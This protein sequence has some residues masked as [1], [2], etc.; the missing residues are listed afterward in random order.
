VKYL[1]I[2]LEGFLS[3]KHLEMDLSSVSHA[4]V[5]G[6]NGS[7]KS[8]IPL[9]IAWVLFG[10]ARFGNDTD[11]I[12][13]DESDAAV[14][15]LTVEDDEG[16]QW[17]FVRGREYGSGGFLR[18]YLLTDGEW[19][20]HSDHTQATAQRD[21]YNVVNISE[22]AFYSLVL[23]DQSSHAGGT[24]FT[25]SDS[26][27]RRSIL[28]G[29]IP[30]LDQW[31]MFKNRASERLSEA[32]KDSERITNQIDSV[33]GQI[34]ST[35]ERRDGLQEQI[36]EDT[37]AAIEAR[38]V[39]LD[40]RITKL[41]KQIAGSG[42]SEVERIQTEIES[43]RTAH[44]LKVSKQQSAIRDLDDELD[45]IEDKEERVEQAEADLT[46]LE[47][48]DEALRSER[49]ALKSEIDDLEP[50]IDE[51]REGVT[52]LEDRMGESTS[53]VE[54][55]RSRL[56]DVR[57]RIDGLELAS[58][59]DNGVCPTCD[60]P[61]SQDKCE[62]LL[63][64]N[65]REKRELGDQ[66]DEAEEAL[67]KLKRRLTDTR[68]LLGTTENRL[69]KAES[70]RDDIKARLKRSAPDI[71]AAQDRVDRLRS[72]LKDLRDPDEVNSALKK[73]KRKLS[74]LNEEFEQDTLKVLEQELS[75]A[76]EDD[77]DD[78]L[79]RELDDL[80]SEREDL[81]T[82]RTRYDRLSGALQESVATLERLEGEVDQL[83]RDAVDK[84][85]L[86]DDLTWA[87]KAAGPK[88]IPSMLLDG[89][90]GAIEDE[91]NRILEQLAG[92]AQMRVEFRQSRENKSGNGSKDVLDIVVHTAGDRERLI[93]S[94]SFGE[95]IRL[96]ISNL[97][98]MIK[99]FNERSG[100]RLISTV[101]LDEPL[102]PLDQRSVPAFIEVLR[103]AMNTG[104]VDSMWVITHDQT[105]IDALPQEVKVSRGP[106]GDSQVV[107]A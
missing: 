9:G 11:S 69:A 33:R 104:I 62:S 103:V 101:F 92:P 53:T 105:V 84:R 74:E 61:L 85:R 40:K 93:E 98:A 71:E 60:S 72:E 2:E 81:A 29:L 6:A 39:K 5:T 59:K 51:H 13:N 73:A 67:G 30:E 25:A 23:M 17:R 76:R 79:R 66:L 97:F 16:N 3:Y 44:D 56:A 87:E 36:G 26:N 34:E 41:T 106:N 20:Q 80:K 42:D 88:G 83:G 15:T 18:S 27:T 21:I 47:N 37:A 100:R 96:S 48:Q 75:R 91:Q 89:I 35:E 46:R 68:T 90:L 19:E 78:Q 107:V 38:G 14:G 45:K 49:K 4:A 63:E 94:F 86:I 55:L 32:K 77:R 7:G 54:R 52:R 102:G 12:V 64:R 8:T 65:K 22:N 58:E 1:H 10:T 43:A 50:K 28:H 70:R 24:K 82:S 95:K 57:D 99:V 31:A